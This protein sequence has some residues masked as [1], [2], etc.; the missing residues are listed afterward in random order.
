MKSHPDTQFYIVLTVDILTAV[1]WIT[2]DP[3]GKVFI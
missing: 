1:T 3:E 2:V